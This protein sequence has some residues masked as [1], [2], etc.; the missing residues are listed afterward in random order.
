MLSFLLDPGNVPFT[1][2]LALMGGIA[3]LEVVTLA[4]G[5]AASGLVDSVLP[6][7]DFDLDVDLDVDTD[8]DAPDLA[9][10]TPALSA[11][12][13]WL[14]IGKV[15][16]L[17]LLAA[18]LLG[19]GLSGLVLQAAVR[20]VFGAALTPWLAWVPALFGSLPVIHVSGRLFRNVLPA[21]ETDAVA[22]KSLI[23][24]TAV[25]TLGIARAGEPAQARLKDDRGQTHYVMVEPRDGSEVQAGEE[26]VLVA[27]DGA[28]FSV[29]PSGMPPIDD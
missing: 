26:V 20:G 15:P 8:V 9:A 11:L 4:F 14:H 24:R 22:R 23:G 18:F 5:A 19:F 10:H 17:I 29:V 13:S 28:K 16:T 27:Q 2:A 21:E 6:D 25:V 7:F 3:A 1:V 12:F